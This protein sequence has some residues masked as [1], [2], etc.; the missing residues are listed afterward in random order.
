[1][2]PLSFAIAETMYR[3]Q[4][5]ARDLS[6]NSTVSTTLYTASQQTTLQILALTFST[7]S[8]ASAILAFYWFVK[9][10]RSFRHDLIMLLIQSDMFKALW[11]MMYPIVTFSRGPVPGNSKFCQVNG[12]FLSLGIEASDFAI[13]Q[14]ALHTALYIFK[15]RISSGEGGLYPY[16]KFAYIC[17]II[18]PVLMASLAF[19]NGR[20]AYDSEE[21]YCYLP[22]RPFWY[23]LAL[24]WIPRYIIF[25]VILCIY[26]S[27]YFYVR[28]KFHGFKR[29]GKP[30]GARNSNSLD[31]E[32]TERPSRK[33]STPAPPSLARHGLI[34]DSRK[35]S[36]IGEGR[37]HSASTMGS[38]RE[39]KARPPTGIHRFMWSN[40]IG[41]TKPAG[42]SSTPLEVPASDIDSFV[43]P[44]TPQPL[45]DLSSASPMSLQ[46]PEPSEMPSRSRVTSWRDTIVRR[47]SPHLSNGNTTEHSLVNIHG[48]LRHPDGSDSPPLSRLELVNSL[49]QNLANAEM[50]RTRDKIRRQLR[51]L[52]IYPLV[53]I[54][55][56]VVPFISHVLQYDDR[57][58]INPPFGLSCAT[59]I[60]VCSQAAVD[61]WL[62]STREKPWRQI[63]GSSG[64]FWE[65]L[66]FWKGW[67][68]A[69]KRKDVRGPG[70]TRGEMV[71]EA[72]VAY[73]R[74]DQELAQKQV[75]NGLGSREDS[76]A[77][78]IL[79]E[80]WE[81][82]A[83]TGMSP[84]AEDVSNPMEDIV[85]SDDST[86]T[87]A[88]LTNVKTTSAQD[89]DGMQ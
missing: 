71:R 33:L 79:K 4:I 19:I 25:M 9:M 81:H 26:A 53:Y 16:R 59:T 41:S 48:I 35:Q 39:R 52:F 45:P 38:F 82:S 37:K 88:T 70:K 54:G 85:R 75:E 6:D 86:S 36:T 62:F 43:G 28:Y 69:S 11:F 77:P 89:T 56:W 61:C 27:I 60:F 47:F 42:S 76:N 51:F 29:A 67:E 18:F 58:A 10:R 23:R 7:I 55:M 50:V 78:R 80:W 32:G 3:S 2:A 73:R 72:R 22:V 21:T 74:R 15:P 68:G 5:I 46:S 14:I 31:S 57:F 34:P 49:G 44:L 13:L 1:M 12:F 30:Q 87:N 66:Q 17:W 40:I 63:P 8:V 84:V 83:E 64:S 20:E 24:A 65:S